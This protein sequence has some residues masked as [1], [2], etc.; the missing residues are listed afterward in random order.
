MKSVPT[1][2]EMSINWYILGR[3]D[4]GVS[5]WLL[6]LTMAVLWMSGETQ[7]RQMI[8]DNTSGYKMERAP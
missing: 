7:D 4:A 8:I 5:M 2:Y 6:V 1:G 3:L